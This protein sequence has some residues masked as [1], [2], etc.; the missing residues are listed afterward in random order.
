MPSILA[1]VFAYAVVVGMAE[2]RPLQ[3]AG[4]W[5]RA[6]A[7]LMLPV[8]LLTAEEALKLVP[9]QDARG[10]LRDGLHP[11]HAVRDSRWWCRRRRRRILTGVHARGGARDAGETAPLLFTARLSSVHGSSGDLHGADQRRS[12]DAD[13]Q[14]LGKSPSR[15]RSTWRGRPRSCWSLMVLDHQRPQPRSLTRSPHPRTLG[16]TRAPASFGACSHGSKAELRQSDPNMTTQMLPRNANGSVR[17]STA[18][19]RSSTTATSWPC[20]TRIVPIPRKG[21]I[22]AF[23]GPS[24]CGKSTVLRCLNRM[25]DLDAGASGSRGTCTSADQDIYAPGVDPVAV[26]RHIGMVFQQPNPVRDER[27]QER[28]VRPAN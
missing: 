13:L 1:G 11:E 20:G 12:R 14:L 10:G 4:G 2:H 26:R 7:V 22:T 18:R 17:R 6:L 5:R 9:D 16:G 19:S 27:P 3:R 21:E 25:N 28:R 15:T 23:I 24:G 8:V